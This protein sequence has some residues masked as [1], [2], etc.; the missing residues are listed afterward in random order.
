MSRDSTSRENWRLVRNTAVSKQCGSIYNVNSFLKW[1]CSSLC[2]FCATLCHWNEISYTNFF[3]QYIVSNVLIIM[4]NFT[5]LKSYNGKC[6]FLLFFSIRQPYGQ[7]FCFLF[8]A[9]EIL[10]LEQK[11][12]RDLEPSLRTFLSHW[13][14]TRRKGDRLS[15]SYLICSSLFFIFSLPSGFLPRIFPSTLDRK[16]TWR[17]RELKGL[18]FP[19]IWMWQIRTV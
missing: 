14:Y 19:K 12:V 3:A 1:R 5:F 13:L 11:Y 6:C 2:H 4:V 16:C 15:Y 8:F 10:F 9:A 7:F 17:W 18:D